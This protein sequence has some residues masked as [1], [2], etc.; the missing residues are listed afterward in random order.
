MSSRYSFSNTDKV[1]FSRAFGSN[2]RG[3]LSQERA[4]NS[5]VV[6]YLEYSSSIL[7][8]TV[9]WLQFSLENGG[10][11]PSHNFVFCLELYLRLNIGTLGPYKFVGSDNYIKTYME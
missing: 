2:I 4:P 7:K 3:N 11:F 9:S 10:G 8:F 6:F 5:F 1:I